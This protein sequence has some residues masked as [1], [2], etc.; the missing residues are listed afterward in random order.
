MRCCGTGEQAPASGT[1]DHRWIVCW[2]EG[3]RGRGPPTDLQRL[4]EP[5]AVHG[6]PCDWMP[7]SAVSLEVRPSG[8]HPEFEKEQ[9][10][11]HWRQCC[12]CCDPMS[13]AIIL[14]K[15]CDDPRPSSP[16]P[17]LPHV[18][19]AAAH[20]VRIK[21]RKSSRTA[22]PRLSHCCPRETPCSTET[23]T[24]TWK[25]PSLYASMAP[26]LIPG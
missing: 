24:T 10:L 21:T 1:K 16:S 25:P 17:E 5:A 9:Q 6:R 22:G 3:T 14:S 7:Y 8:F 20:R 19:I 23:P 15:S 2:E 13:S 11:H 18:A 26:H 4:W 12:P